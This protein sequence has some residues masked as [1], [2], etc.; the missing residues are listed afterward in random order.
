M[1]NGNTEGTWGHS[2][3]GRY[4]ITSA[5]DFNA[6]RKFLTDNKIGNKE[7]D[8]YWEGMKEPAWVINQDDLGAVF[9][10][11]LINDQEFILMLGE[12]DARDRRPAILHPIAAT[13][14]PTYLGM[15]QS[16]TKEVAE[17]TL[18]G[19]TYDPVTQSYFVA[20]PDMDIPTSSNPVPRPVRHV[21]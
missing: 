16:V 17:S 15:Y 19:Y 14:G 10:S 13:T 7:V 21:A 12:C 1:S 3:P 9:E 4:F 18:T 11:G 20:G 5:T 2:V 6:F 8:G